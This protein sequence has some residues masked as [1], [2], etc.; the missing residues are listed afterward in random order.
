MFA[1]FSCPHSGK[2]DNKSD[3]LTT[4]SRVLDSL[5]AVCPEFDE[6]KIPDL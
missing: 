3:T 1:T 6:T 4:I 5:Y 2:M